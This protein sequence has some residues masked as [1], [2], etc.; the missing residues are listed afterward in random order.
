M[1]VIWSAYEYQPSFVLG[2]HGCDEEVGEAILCGKEPHLKR[3]EQK[4]IGLATA[5]TFGKAIL[6]ER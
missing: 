4:Y 1:S 3:S 2:F 5:F 6:V